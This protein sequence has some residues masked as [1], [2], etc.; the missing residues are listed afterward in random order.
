MSLIGWNCRGLATLRAVEFFKELVQQWIQERLDRGLANQQWQN[1]F[2]DA[3]I[4][5]WDVS[6]KGMLRR[7]RSRR[8]FYGVQQYNEE[9]D[10]Y[11]RLLEKREIFWSQRAKQFWLKNGDQNSR[12]FHSFAN[13][14]RKQNQLKGLRNANGEWTDD[15]KEMQ[16]IVVNYFEDLE[17]VNHVTEEQNEMLIQPILK[18]EVKAA[19]FSMHPEK[20]PGEDGLNPAFYQTYWN[21]VGD[22]VYKFCGNFFETGVMQNEVNRT[23]VCLIPKI[24][25]PQ[26]VMDLRPI[27][28]CNVLVRTLSKVLANRL[29]RCLPTLISINQSAFVE[30][31]LLSDNALVAFEINHYIRRKTQGKYGYPGLKIDISK[32]YDRLEWNFLEGMLGKYGFH[33]MWISR[34]MTCIRTVTYSFLQKGEVFGQLNPERG[35]RQGDP[36]SPYLYILCAEG[37]S[38]MIRRNEEVGLI[39]GV[40]LLMELQGCLIFYLQMTAIYSLRQQ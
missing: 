10:K 11:L 17:V 14:R 34:V 39:H 18:E 30:G 1:M 40:K 27:S 24:K 15:D 22:D 28:L 21:I 32:A 35:I 23:V 38:S 5:V 3:K 16:N 36:I 13:G 6:S 20:S 19:I 33:Q 2:P 29:K 37:L 7:L 8:D 4:R 12:F 9:R 26:G 25:N 31:R